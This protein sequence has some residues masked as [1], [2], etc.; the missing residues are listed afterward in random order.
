MLNYPKMNK[1]NWKSSKNVQII[2]NYKWN[3]SY[4]IL[5]ILIIMFIVT[6]AKKLI[7]VLKIIVYCIVGNVI[8]MYVRCVININLIYDQMI[9]YFKI[10]MLNQYN[11]NYRQ[12]LSRF[13][14]LGLVFWVLVSNINTIFIIFN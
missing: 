1:I 8:M 4:H 7:N 13:W 12:Y 3:I 14:Y 11:L 10:Y 6:N 5:H 2:I 9:I